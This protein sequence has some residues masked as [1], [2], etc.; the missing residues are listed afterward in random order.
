MFGSGL[1]RVFV[2]LHSQ[3]DG[4]WR[5]SA[6]KTGRRLKFLR[7]L[8]ATINPKTLFQQNRNHDEKI[9][10]SF[11]LHSSWLHVIGERKSV[12]SGHLVRDGFRPKRPINREIP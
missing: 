12:D 11:V 1:R 5:A 2:R 3:R 9:G 6:A 8:T 10:T 4:I 7:N